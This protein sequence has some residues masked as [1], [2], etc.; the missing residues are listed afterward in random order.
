MPA[1]SG[2]LL[3]RHWHRRPASDVTG[4]GAGGFV[5]PDAWK[6]PAQLDCGGE[7]ATLI[8]GGADRGGIGLRDHEHRAMMLPAADSGKG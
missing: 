6:P 3:D 8:E 5:V 2:R 4:A 7:L 1:P